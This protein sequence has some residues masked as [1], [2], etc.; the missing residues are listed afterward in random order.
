[1]RATRLALDGKSDEARRAHLALC[2]VHEVM[3]VEANPAPVKAALAHNMK[4]GGGV[5][6]PLVPVSEGARARVIAAL[7]TY[8]AGRR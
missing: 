8:E 3:F 2:P 7:E 4:I 6:G 5:R 1:V